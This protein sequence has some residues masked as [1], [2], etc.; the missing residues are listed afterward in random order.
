M[1][2]WWDSRGQAYIELI[3]VLPVLLVLIAGVIFFGRILY[4]KIALDMASYDGV[5]AAVEALEEQ[6][7]ISQGIAAAYNT[8]A[9]FHINPAGAGIEVVSVGPWTR[10][11]QVYCRVSYN[12]NVGDI[13]FLGGFFSGLSI[14]LR[15]TTWSR[16]E[17][18][19][20]EW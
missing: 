10:G 9:G 15:S 20:S 14:P 8:L 18:L 3:M 16:V 12:L 7:G 19:R 1:R 6:A 2:T 17:T 4:L 11:A 13:P 5:R